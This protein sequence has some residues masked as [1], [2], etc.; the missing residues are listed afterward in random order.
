MRA[1][2]EEDE[3][4]APE[5]PDLLLLMGRLAVQALLQTQEPLGKLRG[6]T[7][8][9]AGVAAVASYDAPYLLRNQP[10]K[11]RAWDDLCRAQH[12]SRQPRPA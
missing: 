9:V 5:R 6:Q 1:D 2:E 8:Q 11:A 4:E 3:G 10:D 7:L 12:L